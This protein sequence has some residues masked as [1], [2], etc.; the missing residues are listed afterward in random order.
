MSKWKQG[1]PVFW[2]VVFIGGIVVFMGAV[3]FGLY[4][5]WLATNEVGIRL[6]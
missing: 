3:G 5:L 4:D 1:T 2:D 6:I